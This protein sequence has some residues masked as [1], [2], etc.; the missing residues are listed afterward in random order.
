ML[1]DI[2]LMD[3]DDTLFD[4][5]AAE[6]LNFTQTL[7]I[8]GVEATNEAY[9]RFH[10]I[11]VGL[12]QAFERGEIEKGLIKTERFR[13]LF[14]EFGIAADATAVAKSYLTRFKEICIPFPGAKELLQKLKTRGKIY[15]VTNGNT[16][17]QR[18]HLADSGFD[19]LCDGLFISDEM[20]VAKP[21]KEFA[22]TVMKTIAD[23]SLERAVWIGD[24]LTSDM[25]CALNAGIDFILFA[26]RGVPQNFAGAYAENYGELL[27]L[28][29]F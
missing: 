11:N 13:L 2:F 7:S 14:E 29:G 16:E 15:I 12:W 4:F 28:L 20:G 9:L 19:K 22:Q 6:Q 5:H 18:R 27:A 3:M 24:S 10:D 26:P 25:Q 23:F 1:K 21:H 17:I 8:F